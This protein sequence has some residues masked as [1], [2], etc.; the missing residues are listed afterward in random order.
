MLTRLQLGS[1]P[2]GEYNRH[3]AWFDF[4]AVWLN[5]EHMSVEQTSLEPSTLGYARLASERKLILSTVR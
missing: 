4:T 5:T 3:R 1:S 2:N